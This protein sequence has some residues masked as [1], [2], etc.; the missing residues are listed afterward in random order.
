MDLR[1]FAL[2]FLCCCKQGWM[3]EDVAVTEDGEAPVIP[4]TPLIPSKPKSDLDISH[5][6]TSSPTAENGENSSE[7]E[8]DGLCGKHLSSPEIRQAIGSG[9]MKFGL[10]LLENLKANSEQPNVIISPLSVSLALSQLALGARNETEELLFQHLHADAVPCYHKAVK[11]LLHRVRRNALQIASRIY[12]GPGFQPKQEF[13]QE[14]LKIY[15]S[16]PAILTELE[17][18][19]E[20]VEKST[21]G[22]V[23][24]FLTSLPPNLVMMLI[25]AVHYK[26]EWLTRFDPRF[27]ATEPFYIDENLMVNVDMMLGPKYPLSVFTHNEL[28]AQ[29]A[30]FPFKGNMSLV[31]VMPITGNVNVT[32]I[33]ANLNISNLYSRFPRERNMQVKLPKFKLDFSQELDEALRSMGLGELF[34]SP[35]LAGISDGPLLVSSVQHK[36]SMEINEEGAEAAAT[37]SVVISRS[38]PSFTVNQPFFLALMDDSSQTPLFLGVI[39]NPNP[40]GSAM[41]SNPSDSDKTGFVSD[42][43]DVPSFAL[44]PK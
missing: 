30:H 39:S 5:G 9:I 15:D 17:E 16:E 44:P 35:N 22:Y 2:L 11:S 34:T 37:T 1:L 12:L 6:A 24:D 38:N 4:L 10:Q 26:G 23:T 43:D 31:I 41:I 40:S 20:W 32:A 36:S 14:S 3:Q 21:N 29:V 18:V 25:N 28:D 13:I 42:K 8:L 19:N 7:E 27:T 33:A